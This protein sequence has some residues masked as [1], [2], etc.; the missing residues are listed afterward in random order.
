MVKNDSF[1]QSYDNDTQFVLSYELVCLLRWLIEHNEPQLKGLIKKALSAGLK[2]ELKC[3]E[4]FNQAQ[5]CSLEEIQMNIVD[6]FSML[7]AILLETMHEQAVQATIEKNLM[8]A[9]EHIDAAECDTAVISNSIE[10]VVSKMDNA[11][12]ERA[13]E[14]LFQEILRQWKPSK[15]KKALN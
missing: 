2:K 13:Q 4:S 10:R 3:T 9:I 12:T 14:M 15:K 7:E 1:A 5:Q 11:S 8:P 6:F